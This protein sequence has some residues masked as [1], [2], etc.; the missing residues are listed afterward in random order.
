VKRVD[1]DPGRLLEMAHRLLHRPDAATAG[2]WPRVSALL[3]RRALEACVG[4]L[5]NDRA[6]PLHACSMRT[7]F[8]CLRTYL[9]DTDLAAR[10]NHAW[11]ALTRACHHHPYELAP[12]A[13]E[14]RSWFSVVGDLIRKVEAEGSATGSAGPAH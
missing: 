4:E 13:T 2:L 3:A 7:Q 5:W 6:L 10:T 8:L 1:G 9:G 11:S 14:L 12:T